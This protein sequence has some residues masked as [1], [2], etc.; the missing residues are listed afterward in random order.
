MKRINK[1][2]KILISSDIF[3]VSA[4]GFITP[5]FAVFLTE[6]IQGSN[7]K[8]VGYA[9]AIYLITK[10]LLQIP[11]SRYLDKHKGEKDD[12][13]AVI[14]GNFLMSAVFFSYTFASLPWHI[15]VLEILYA[16]G[17]AMN[18]PGYNAIFSRHLDHGNEAINW[19]LHSSLVDLGTGVA[20][21]LGGFIVFHLGFNY[22]FIAGG[23]FCCISAILPLVVF[24]ELFS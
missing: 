5:V 13:C 12:L 3:L 17:A 7:I 11:I 9:A 24:K 8:I 15:Y 18:L 6:H 19:G 23:F 14:I 4:G 22:V 1:V 2:I 10:S 20:G 21:A 16:I